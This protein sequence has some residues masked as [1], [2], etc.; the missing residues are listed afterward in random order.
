[1]APRVAI[2]LVDQVHVAAAAG[3]SRRPMRHLRTQRRLDRLGTPPRIGSAF[4][5]VHEHPGAPLLE[6]IEKAA[7]QRGL[8]NPRLADDGD[9]LRAGRRQHPVELVQFRCAPDERPMTGA[10]GA[11]IDAALGDCRRLVRAR[12]SAGRRATAARRPREVIRTCRHSVFSNVTRSAARV[13]AVVPR[14][15]DDERLRIGN[16]D[17]ADRVR[18][19]ELQKAIE[20]G[21]RHVDGR[22][23]RGSS[24]GN[25]F[26]KARPAGSPRRDRAGRR[27]A[28]RHPPRSPGRRSDTP[29]PAA[30]ASAPASSSGRRRPV[31][32]FHH[33]ARRGEED[34]LNAVG[35]GRIARSDSRLICS[36]ERIGQG[37]SRWATDTISCQARIEQVRRRRRVAGEAR[38]RRDVSNMKPWGVCDATISLAH[39][40]AS[41]EASGCG[42]SM[43]A[44]R[45]SGNS[46]RAASDSTRA[47]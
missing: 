30:G 22:T 6:L 42:S 9:V 31:V 32:R 29:A 3:R 2:Q 37:A 20:Q 27:V 40:S 47:S 18:A 13:E 8:P 38:P 39:R 25:Q 23:A 21:D 24:Q 43:R 1:M 7:Q 33:L 28:R 16:G 12:G 26:S 14:H 36:S 19:A 46:M 34:L 44:R 41:A 10:D 4:D 35:V 5:K 15:V 45:S 17:R 11:E